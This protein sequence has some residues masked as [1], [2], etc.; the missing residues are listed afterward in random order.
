M[1]SQSKDK[2]Q[3][4]N[5]YQEYQ[6]RIDNLMKECES[7]VL[8]EENSRVRSEWVARHHSHIINIRVS[9]EKYLQVNKGFKGTDSRGTRSIACSRSS[10]ESA[11]STTRA[12][13]AERKAKLG[14]ERAFS[15]KVARLQNE[16]RKAELDK[17]AMEHDLLERELNKL[18]GVEENVHQNLPGCNVEP[19]DG[20]PVT[21][22]L[23]AGGGHQASTR[24]HEANFNKDSSNRQ[25]TPANDFR[26]SNLNR[27]TSGRQPRAANNHENTLMEILRQ[28]NEITLNMTRQQSRS[29]LPKKELVHFDG[30]DITRFQSFMRSFMCNIHNKCETAVDKLYYLEQFTA[31]AAQEIV[32]SCNNS[33]A[34]KAYRQ[35]LQ[36]LEEEYGNEHKTAAAY[37]E[38]LENWPPIKNEDGEKLKELSTYLLTCC[39]S[40]WTT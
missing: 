2:A 16:L 5:L 9:I 32:R 34:N 20:E 18:E 15:E 6:Q 10:A 40:I 28:Q 21:L 4:Q 27:D 24:D 3:L 36:L 39:N 23:I 7:Q 30:S 17:Q 14:A 31:G 29:E 35:A 38:K 26:P 13:L 8:N 19:D 37:L 33:D 11:T 1:N 12:R 22:D 25:Q